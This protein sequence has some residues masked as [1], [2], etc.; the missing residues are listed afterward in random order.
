MFLFAFLVG[1]R[2]LKQIP[3][4]RSMFSLTPGVFFV[5]DLWANQ[6]LF[7]S[8]FG[9]MISVVLRT[10]H[11][12]FMK[13]RADCFFLSAIYIPKFNT[14]VFYQSPIDWE[15]GIVI[16]LSLVY[17]VYCELWKLARPTMYKRWEEP[18]VAADVEEI[19]K[20]TKEE[21]KARE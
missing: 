11:F 17:V 15:W 9:G 4:E 2:G 5:K 1:F 6:V 12:H 7:W 16:A 10:S 21:E 13:H 18:L 14:K 20:E 3:V 19:T 8:V